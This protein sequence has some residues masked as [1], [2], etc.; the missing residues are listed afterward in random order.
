[1]R[2]LNTG[3][4]GSY[5]VF[6]LKKYSLCISKCRPIAHIKKKLIKK[7]FISDLDSNTNHAAVM[8]FFIVIILNQPF[9]FVLYSVSE[10]QVYSVLFIKSM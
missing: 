1:M 5:A 2:G 4:I 7:L 9:L 8:S 3:F 10:S 6:C